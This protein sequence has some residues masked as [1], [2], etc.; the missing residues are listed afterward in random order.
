MKIGRGRYDPGEHMAAHTKVMI[1]QVV[2]KSQ[3]LIIYF[4][5]NKRN[6]LMIQILDVES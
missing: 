4:E 1:V 2:T 3:I 5:L 6:L